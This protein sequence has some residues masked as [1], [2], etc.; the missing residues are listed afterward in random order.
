[1]QSA[2]HPNPNMHKPDNLNLNII[3][4]NPKSV[5]KLVNDM[6]GNASF[7]QVCIDSLDFFSKSDSVD[8]KTFFKTKMHS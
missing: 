8:L 1:M 2:S 6:I 5:T 7:L 3:H 4:I